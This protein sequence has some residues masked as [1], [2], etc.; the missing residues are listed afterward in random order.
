MVRIFRFRGMFGCLIS[1][2]C[3]LKQNY[4]LHWRVLRCVLFHTE[5]KQWEKEV[6][7]D[8]LNVRD[9]RIPLSS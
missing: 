6:I 9:A 8:V 5:G 7:E 2:T 3:G 1:V 4:Q